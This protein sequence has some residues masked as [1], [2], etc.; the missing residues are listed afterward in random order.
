MACAAAL[1]LEG[2]VTGG[3]VFVLKDKRRFSDVLEK[4]DVLPRRYGSCLQSG[5]ELGDRLAG[6]SHTIVKSVLSHLAERVAVGETGLFISVRL[7]THRGWTDTK[8][9]GAY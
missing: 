6:V 7:A 9:G 3:L 8:F 2:A 1:E 4:A 5:R